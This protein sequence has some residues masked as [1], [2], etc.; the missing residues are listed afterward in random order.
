MILVKLIEKITEQAKWERHVDRKSYDQEILL[1]IQGE[2][3]RSGRIY[4]IWQDG[5]SQAAAKE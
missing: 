2:R 4:A 5:P 1:L 3:F